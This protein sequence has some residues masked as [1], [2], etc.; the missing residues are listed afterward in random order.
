M[1]TRFLHLSVSLFL[2]LSILAAVDWAVAA[3]LVLPDG[4]LP[5]DRRLEPLK[6]LDGYFPFAPPK[7]KS[8]CE[9]RAERVRK[10]I[11]MSQGLWPMATKTPL[12]PVIHGKID[13]GEYSV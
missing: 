1:T 6:D 3:P 12:N 7:S 8:D 11:L 13:C 10:Q 2:T 4:Q 9:K 5:T